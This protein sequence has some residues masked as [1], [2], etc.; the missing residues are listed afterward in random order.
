[1]EALGFRVFP[2]DL[3]GDNIIYRNGR[4]AQINLNEPL[5]LKDEVMDYVVCVEGIE[6]LENP[7]FLIREFARVLKAGGRLIIMTPNV[8]SINS[9]VRFLLY[10]YLEHFRYF[11]PLPE[12]AKHRTIGYEHVHLTP[13][14]YP[15]MRHMLEKYGFTIE[16]IEP[17]R[18]VKRWPILHSFLKPVIRYKTSRRYNDP[19]YLSNVLLEG[20]VLVFVAKK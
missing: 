15:Q 4:C 1:M 2:G 8:M 20:E 19:F 11:G 9:R 6:H 17:S 18:R 12:E 7:F 3:A 13:V 10:S 16:R 14:S 5:P